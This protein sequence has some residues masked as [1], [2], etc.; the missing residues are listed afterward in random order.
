MGQQDDTEHVL[1][2]K[3]ILFDTRVFETSTSSDLSNLNEL[4]NTF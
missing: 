4:H 3:Q 1:N 2:F